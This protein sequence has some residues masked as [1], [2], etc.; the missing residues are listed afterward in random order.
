M[1]LHRLRVPEVEVSMQPLHRL[2]LLKRW[3]HPSWNNVRP[4]AVAAMVLILLASV[5]LPA[6]QKK[7]K[8]VTVNK[9]VTVKDVTPPDVSSISTLMPL[10][11]AQ[12]IELMLS[13]MLAAWQIGDDQIL[14]TFYADDVLVVSGAWEPPLQGWQNYLRAYQAQRARTQGV[15]LE[16]TNTFTKV[17]GSAAWCTYQWEFTGQVDGAPTSAVGQTTLML[18]KRAGKWLIVANHTSVAPMP[19]KPVSSSAAPNPQTLQPVASR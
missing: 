14:H 18:E 9:N 2:S 1:S 4:A 3:V 17:V 6:A 12:G 8:D 5:T 11:D 16:R 7:N 13:Q 19:Q 10:P 15:R